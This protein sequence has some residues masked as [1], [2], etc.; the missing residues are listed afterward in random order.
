MISMSPLASFPIVKKIQD[1][2]IVSF[3]SVWKLCRHFDI[4]DRLEK[5]AK[6][7]SDF[8]VV[9]TECAEASHDLMLVED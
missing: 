3:A 9:E 4:M 5:E 8:W 7:D 1:R 2:G 6:F